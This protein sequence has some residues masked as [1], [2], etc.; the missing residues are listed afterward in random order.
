M[1]VKPPAPDLLERFAAICGPAYALSDPATMKPY[2]TE[3]RAFYEAHA[4]LVLRP[5]S[6]E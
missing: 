3:P 5:G 1:S 6:V 2:L 4:P